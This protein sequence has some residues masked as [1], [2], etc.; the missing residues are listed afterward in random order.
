MVLIERLR[1]PGVHAALGA[2][3]LFGAATPLAKRLLQTI[4]PWLLAGLLYLGSGLGLILYRQLVRVG[5]VR[6][7]RSQILWLAGAIVAGGVAGPVLLML[8]LTSMPA[9]GASLLLNAESAFTALLAWFVFRE[10]FDRRIALGMAA[11]VAGAVILAWPGN[12]RFARVWP[13]VAILGACLAWGID[14]NL[15]R[16]VSLTDA[17][18]IASIK[19]LTAGSVN[20]TLA[21]GLGA[22]TPRIPDVASAMILG[23]FAYGVSLA[24]FVV[25]LRHLGTARTGAYFSVAPFLGAALAVLLGDAVTPQL[26][27][28]GALMAFGVWLHLT[29][30]HEHEHFHET[31]EHEHE[32]VHGA[33]PHHEHQHDPPV[34]PGTRHTHPHRHEPLRHAHAHFPDAHHRHRH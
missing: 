28:A 8:G 12:V 5:R 18:W 10:N 31:F 27:T 2:A 33:D 1:Q 21:I 20:L 24:L 14:N 26:L 25:A 22:H 11:I 9:S 7:A 34:A 19:G 6:L 17:T 23:L 32:H 29:E 15:T 13:A 4:D 16:K 30:R 3:V